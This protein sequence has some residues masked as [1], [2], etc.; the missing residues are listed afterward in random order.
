MKRRNCSPHTVKNYL[1]I[2]RHLVI[3]LDVLLE[4]ATH[5]TISRY[6]DHL[7]R[8]RLAPQTINCHV[9]CIR[10]FYHYLRDEEGL[11]IAHPVLGATSRRCLVLYPGI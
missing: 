9:N 4:D 11:A 10:Q 8:N 5:L 7:M 2:I 1:S 6:I 3:W